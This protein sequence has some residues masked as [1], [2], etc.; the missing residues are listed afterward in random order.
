M[1]GMVRFGNGRSRFQNSRVGR[2]RF[3]II[4]LDVLGLVSF[5]IR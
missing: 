2:S 3:E 4:G 5:R 1:L